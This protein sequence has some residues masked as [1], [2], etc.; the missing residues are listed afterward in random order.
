[1][2]L[3]HPT[4]TNAAALLDAVSQQPSE[5]GGADRLALLLLSRTGRNTQLTTEAHCLPNAEHMEGV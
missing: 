3:M 2:W 5:E 1:M 4:P